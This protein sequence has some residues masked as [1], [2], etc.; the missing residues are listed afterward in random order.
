MISMI[1][2]TLRLCIA[3]TALAAFLPIVPTYAQVNFAFVS[4]NGGGSTCTP[5]QPCATVIDALNAVPLNQP[6]RIICLNGSAWTFTGIGFAV[7]VSL[8]IDCPQGPVTSIGFIMGS[9]TVRMR[10]VVFDTFGGY[11]SAIHVSGSGTLILEDCV[12]T[13]SPNAALDME[14][15]GSLNLVI[16]SSRMSNNGSGILLKPAAGGSINAI[17]DHVTIADNA[18]AGLRIDTTDGPVTTDITDSVVSKNAGNGINAI[19]NAGGQALVS[20]KNSVIAENGTAGVQANGAN[21]G[22]LMQTTLL[23]QNAAGAT[24]AVSGGHISTYGNNSIVGS[25]GSGF[26]ATAAL[27]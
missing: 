19:G 6:V 25:A 8:D 1:R 5:A 16:R 10:H 17:L 7:G 2:A 13:D 23:D 4:A 20:I 21:A 9:S 18:G 27:Q 11:L 24:S 26:T 14:P 3:V 22:I 15:T 12:F